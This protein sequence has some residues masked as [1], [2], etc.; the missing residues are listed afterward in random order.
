PRS[1]STRLRPALVAP[2]SH[3]PPVRASGKRTAVIR[4]LTRIPSQGPRS[5][6]QTSPGKMRHEP[7]S[8]TPTQ[9]GTEEPARP[10]YQ[11]ERR[12]TRDAQPAQH[13][14]APCKRPPAA[15]GNRAHRWLGHVGHA[16][17]PVLRF[18]VGHAGH[19]GAGRVDDYHWKPSHHSWGDRYGR[20][21]RPPRS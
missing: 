10:P 19:F 17:R 2:T 5:V 20:E 14:R 21:L 8:Q 12:A 15:A 6:L 11:A 3:E 9:V 16:E 1:T 13:R 7:N 4:G 18:A